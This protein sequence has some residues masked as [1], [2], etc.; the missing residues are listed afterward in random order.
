[1]IAEERLLELQEVDLSIARLEARREQLE[2]GEDVR[3]ARERMQA[4]E[5]RVG[6]LRLALDAVVTELTKL[7]NN[8]DS[9]EKRIDAERRRLYDGSV[10][11]P[12]EL[13]AIQAEIRNLTD[14]KRRVED[15]E[16]DQ[17][18]R[19]EDMEGRLPQLEAELAEART[20]LA[21]IAAGSETELADVARALEERRAERAAL[22]GQLDGE[23]LDLYEDLRR[24]KRG[25]GVAALVDGVCQGCHQK[26]SAAELDRIKRSEGIRRCEYCRRILV[27]S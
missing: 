1:M 22:A 16:L 27:L 10:A 9:L 24:T 26:L 6:E 18:E 5:E 8:A 20:R 17:M 4:A 14:R 23:L 21:E 13:E 15:L 7:E 11:N 12:K 19:R 3:V 2:G 25:V